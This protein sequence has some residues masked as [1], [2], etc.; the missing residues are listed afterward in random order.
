VKRFFILTLCVVIITGVFAVA[1]ENIVKFTYKS[2]LE[3]AVENSVQPE[4][5]DYNIKAKESA[6]EK[7]KEEA[8]KGFLAERL[9]KLWKEEL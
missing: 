7:A 4:L 6:L 1:E 8:I 3:T 2:A 5:D 9:R